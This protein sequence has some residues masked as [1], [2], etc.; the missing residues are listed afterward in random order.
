MERTV[1]KQDGTSTWLNSKAFAGDPND[2]FFDPDT[3]PLDEEMG[4]GHLNAK[5]A[6]QQFI[7]GEFDLTPS[8]ADQEATVPAIGWDFGHTNGTFGLNRYIIDQELQ[9]G[10]VISITLAWDRLV[11]KNGDPNAFTVGD[12]FEEYTDPDADDVIND[13]DLFL[14][15]SDISTQVLFSIASVGTVEHIFASVPYTGNFEIW[16]TQEDADVAGGQDYGLAWWY[17]L[18][19]E[20]EAPGPGDFDGDGDVDGE[21]LALW[22]GSYALNDGGDAD[23]DGDSDGDDF[24][25]WQRNVGTGVLSA[26]T[27]VP[28]PA[29]GLLAMMV[30]VVAARRRCW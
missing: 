9:G 3:M 26:A 6:L 7:P 4:T 1:V 20:L 8:G 13:L 17:G 24:L 10:N 29:T 18:A 23:G 15:D 12:T 25:I 5:R 2:P 16:V 27:A 21:D 28:E 14:V 11:E 19:P 30:L 22:E